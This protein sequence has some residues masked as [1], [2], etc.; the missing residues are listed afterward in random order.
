MS[1]GVY[2]IVHAASGARYI[3]SSVQVKARLA[4]HKNELRKGIHHCKKLQTAYDTLGAEGWDFQVLRWCGRDELREV[5]QFEMDRVDRADLLNTFLK[6]VVQLPSAVLKSELSKQ[7]WAT[8]EV[9]TR[10]CEGMKKGWAEKVIGDVELRAMRTRAEVARAKV[11]VASM[12]ANAV[13]ARAKRD[14]LLATDTDGSFH[15]SLGKNSGNVKGSIGAENAKA[16]WTR[17]MQD[18][19]F[20]AQMKADRS[21]KM[22]AYRATPE[23]K[24]AHKRS[25]LAREANRRLKLEP[26]ET[27]R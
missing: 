13:K 3:G 7:L 19:E 6:A 1:V 27:S 11:T 23:G 10:M 22:K 17:K 18:P 25:L 14:L 8:P 4:K 26:L 20:A 21:A 16:T 5:E 9:R 24:E 15:K 2:E 12:Q